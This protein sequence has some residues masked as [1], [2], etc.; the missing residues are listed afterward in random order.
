MQIGADIG[1]SPEH[2]SRFDEAHSNDHARPWRSQHHC[3]IGDETA[4][5]RGDSVA[6]MRDGVAEKFDQEGNGR[7]RKQAREY[8][9]DP[10]P[11]EEIAENSACSLTEQLTENLAR[12]K[13][14]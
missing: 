14:A 4:R 5:P 2:K 9:E 8:K 12:K 11:S 7:N 13:R 1:E 10:T 6:R 3:V